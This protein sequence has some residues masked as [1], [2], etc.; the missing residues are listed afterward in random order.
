MAFYDLV[1]QIILILLGTG[2]LFL[3]GIG[4]SH[5]QASQAKN[6]LFM[7]LPNPLIGV[8]GKHEVRYL[9]SAAEHLLKVSAKQVLGRSFEEIVFKGKDHFGFFFRDHKEP[10]EFSFDVDGKKIWYGLQV[11]PLSRVSILPGGYM[12]IFYDINSYKQ[13]EVALEASQN[14]YR[15][16]TEQAD[17][18]IAI[19]KN[20]VVV[21]VNPRLLAMT[22]YLPGDILY[23]QF[24]YFVPQAHVLDLEEGFQR[25]VEGDPKPF[26]YETLLKRQDET[27]FPVE[28][29]IG[30]MEFEGEMA[31]L[32]M[33][34]DIRARKQAEQQL[35]LQSKALQAAANGFVITDVDGRIQWVNEAFTIMT[36]YFLEDVVGKTPRVFKSGKQ[37]RAF[38]EE[39]WQIIKAGQIW[40]GELINRKKGGELYYEQLTIA[41]VVDEQGAIT[42]FVAI[43]D[44]ISARKQADLEL[45]RSEQQFRELAMNAPIA[46]MVYNEQHQLLLL[47][48]RFSEILGYQVE[49]VPTIGHWWNLAFT[50]DATRTQIKAEWDRHFNMDVQDSAGFIPIETEVRC[51][52]GKIRFMRFSLVPLGDKYLVALLDLT[53]QKHAEQRLFQRARHLAILND[54]TSLA[55]KNNDLD[56]LSQEL[57]DQMGQLFEADGCYITLWDEAKRQTI[58]LAAYGPMRERYR[59]MISSLLGE[60]TLTEAVLTLGHAIPV[61]DVF[62]S[63]FTSSRIAENFPSHSLLGLPLIADDR[64]LGAAL[65]SYE[66]GHHFTAEEIESGEQVASQ[67]ALGLAKVQL[68]MAEREKRKLSL[69]LVEISKLLSAHLNAKTLLTHLLEFLQQVL[70]YDGGNVFV[71]E[72]G[73]TRVLFTHGYKTYGKEIDDIVKSTSFEIKTTPNLNWMV[74][75]CEPLVIPDTSKDAKWL[76]VNPF[77]FFHSWAG[78]P[79]HFNGEVLAI[80]SLEKE[81]ADF[82]QPEHKDRLAAFAGQA[83]VALE[84]ARLFDEV[85]Q[86]AMVDPLTAVFTRRRILEL[87]TQE[88]ERSRRYVHPMCLCM[89]DIDHFKQVND[90]YGHLA[91]DIVLQSVI[92]NVRNVLRRTDQIGRY[93]G[94]EFL[95]MLPETEMVHAMII[96]ERIRN[97]IEKL[98]IPTKTATIHVTVSIGVSR[99]KEDLQGTPEEVLKDLI[100]QADQALY[101]AKEAGR[102]CIARY[103]DPE[104][105]PTHSSPS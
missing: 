53:K 27:F 72:N 85:R 54:I 69:A 94:E 9:N 83:A 12:I 98:P 38:Y 89:L 37:A 7:E 44:D 64:K 31:A 46:M 14:L 74:Q 104:S 96:A 56:R 22:G 16:V 32:V 79:I 1:W 66:K 77:D 78:A 47:N 71:I 35:R 41:P 75:H 33:L 92:H 95:I 30:W 49:D 17:D 91:G 51:K 52:N 5:R 21:Y 50:E 67:V 20:R 8:N 26:I 93:G 100:D 45:R 82:F 65:I 18:G 25:R 70:P 42:N 68:F 80:I 34:Q 55:L 76:T 87:S 86:L 60:P 59:S 105:F 73:L 58:P 40:Q 99:F 15:N 62:N 57:A 84:N 48:W 36:G 23:R 43:K 88:I 4:Y 19:I 97:R 10:L 2:A 81:E 39:M 11:V 29:K 103:S 6:Q 101:T 63:P 3:L 28:V 13:L 102:N 90:T 24:A 61:E